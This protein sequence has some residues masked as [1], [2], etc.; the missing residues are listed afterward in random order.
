[1][2]GDAPAPASRR[3]VPA[4]SASTS[5]SRGPSHRA[6]VVVVDGP[7]AG[8]GLACDEP[9]PLRLY[10]RESDR[11]RRLGALSALPR[12]A[13]RCGCATRCPRPTRP[14][15]RRCAP[16]RT[17][18]PLPIAPRRGWLLLPLF[19]KSS[20]Q[21]CPQ[22]RPEQKRS[23]QR[24]AFRAVSDCRVWRRTASPLAQRGRRPG[25]PD[26]GAPPRRQRVTIV[27]MAHGVR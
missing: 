6:L 12:C 4:R 24:Q 27:A 1:V 3:P 11:N 25:R 18:V 5:P 10:R 19:V 9:R 23:G 26:G 14:R 2:P 8:D 16:A 7:A 20:L 21:K 17:D 22:L 15:P 13:W